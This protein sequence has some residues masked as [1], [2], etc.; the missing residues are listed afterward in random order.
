MLDSG[1]SMHGSMV[2]LLKRSLLA[3]PKAK[4]SEHEA[5]SVL[6]DEQQLLV[7]KQQPITVATQCR[8]D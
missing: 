2:L 3:D 6:D 7:L 8:S 5:S 4:P 1:G